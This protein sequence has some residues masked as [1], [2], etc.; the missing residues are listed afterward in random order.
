[1]RC[2]PHE[3]GGTGINPHACRVAGKPQ[4]I[5]ARKPKPEQTVLNNPPAAKSCAAGR[6]EPHVD[7]VNE[8]VAEM[9]KEKPEV[10]SEDGGIVL[11]RISTVATSKVRWLWTGRVPF[12]AFTLLDGEANLGKSSIL[13]ALI[14]DIT[15]GPRLDGG[16]PRTGL[17]AMVLCH[18]MGVGD[19]IKGRLRA[20]GAKLHGCLFPEENGLSDQM[21]PVSFPA[22]LDWLEEMIKAHKIGI[23][24]LDSLFDFLSDGFD[25]FQDAPA[26]KIVGGL[27]KV[28]RRTEAAIVAIRHPSKQQGRSAMNQGLGAKCVIGIAR[29]GLA[30]YKHPTVKDWRC[31]SVVKCNVGEKARTL[32]YS[33]EKAKGSVKIKIE[34]ESDEQ[35]ED[36]A[37]G[38]DSP[39]EKDMTMEAEHFLK[40]IL[41]DGPVPATIIKKKAEDAM[42]PHRKLWDAK[43]KL[44][45][46]SK[47]EGTGENICNKWHAPKGGW[48]KGA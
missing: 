37:N 46:T 26:R 7:G 14:A 5:A 35:A 41:A 33:L 44:G 27:Q 17:T 4:V 22:K 16:K 3:T 39:G 9:A 30:V 6:E 36:L 29:A 11:R 34:G 18:E 21:A 8:E 1:M 13:A 24:G 23:V 43:K 42:I 32:N 15:G 47:R 2:I 45:V 48:P 19:Q 40:K 10:Q 31:L 38:Q 28:A 12:G 20:A 25:I